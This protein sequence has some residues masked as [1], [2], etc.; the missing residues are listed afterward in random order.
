M[1]S[2]LSRIT[3]A[4]TGEIIQQLPDV[5]GDEAGPKVLPEYQDWP[6]QE[7]ARGLLNMVFLFFVALWTW[8]DVNP[9]HVQTYHL[10]EYS[11]LVFAM[12]TFVFAFSLTKWFTLRRVLAMRCWLNTER[13]NILWCVAHVALLICFATGG[14][15]LCRIAGGWRPV[16]N[17]SE[18]AAHMI[19]A[20]G[21]GVATA[22]FGG[23]PF[24]GILILLFIFFGSQPGW[25]CYSSMGRGNECS[26]HPDNY[27]MFDWFLGKP[28]LVGPHA[29]SSLRMG[30]RDWAGMFLRGLVWF[31]PP[32][33]L[34]QT[35]LDSQKPTVRVGL[36]AVLYSFRFRAAPYCPPNFIL[37]GGLMPLMY[38]LGWD[39]PNSSSIFNRGSQLAEFIW[40]FASYWAFGVALIAFEQTRAQ[41]EHHSRRIDPPWPCCRGDS[42]FQEYEEISD[43]EFEENGEFNYEKSVGAVFRKRRRQKGCV[44]E[45][46]M[47]FVVFGVMAYVQDILMAAVWLGSLVTVLTVGLVS[48]AD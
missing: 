30:A 46:N 41:Q 39:I 2:F 48:L 26:F 21:F 42:A 18:D 44:C 5:A 27:G 40:G 13:S 8:G 37:L 36:R 34:L 9:A 33:F 17:Y 28:V 14:A 35:A 7:M 25:D 10:G 19:F 15:Y 4:R 22:L 1:S 12:L 24:L 31:V 47:T 43:T 29:W 23:N 38:E 32:G 3:G 16:G 6:W 20:L 45:K 11:D